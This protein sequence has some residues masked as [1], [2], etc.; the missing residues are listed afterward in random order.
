MTRPNTAHEVRRLLDGLVSRSEQV[1]S[2]VVLSRDGLLVAA[3][4]GLGREDSEHL[5]ALVAGV[6]GLAR[7]ACRHFEGGE[8][9]QT[10]IEMDTELL[11]MATAG[12]DS[13][14][15][16]LSG[17]DPDAG[18]IAFEMTALAPRLGEFLPAD[19]RPS[20]PGVG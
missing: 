19:P 13:C 15:A 5:S 12:V 16:V 18:T 11:F 20:G 8:V 9:L 2:A 14:L 17:A 6:Q 7:G 3:S 1:E 10:V 4:S